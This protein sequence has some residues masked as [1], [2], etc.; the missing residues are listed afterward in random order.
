[1]DDL[2]HSSVKGVVIRDD[3]IL[4]V[5]YD[6]EGTGIHYNL[7]GGRQRKDETLHE[8]LRRKMMEEAG[9][10]VDVG[11]LLFVYEF[12]GKNHDY[13]DGPKHSLS[14][15]FKCHLRPGSEPSMKTCTK[16]EIG[17]QTDVTWL[18]LERFSTV[19]FWPSVP[20]AIVQLYK[21]T[22]PS[23]DRYLGDIL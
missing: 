23:S 3:K 19:K 22:Q 1:M 9:A 5:E 7:P 18:P 13:F 12:I 16:P 15:V 6:E 2:F 4:L 17:M 8:A 21:N 14:L 11:P 10:D 20:D